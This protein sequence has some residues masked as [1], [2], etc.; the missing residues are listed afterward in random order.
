MAKK[1]T[2]FALFNGVFKLCFTLM[3][4]SRSL[5]QSI[6]TLCCS[7]SDLILCLQSVI[8]Y[9]AT[10]LSLISQCN[11]LYI[12]DNESMGILSS[13][14]SINN[15]D[16]KTSVYAVYFYILAIQ[17]CNSKCYK[18][19][20]NNESNIPLNDY[21]CGKRDAKISLSGFPATFRL[22]SGMVV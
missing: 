1:K 18:V 7:L 15:R 6:S 20:A 17:S 19:N 12:G 2:Y 11:I 13:S 10:I 16:T 5:R 3:E 8:F 9:I 4:L 14:C 22:A 21:F